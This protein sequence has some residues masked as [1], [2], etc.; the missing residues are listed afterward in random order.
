MIPATAKNTAGGI[1][2]PFPSLYSLPPFRC[3]GNANKELCAHTEQ[4]H[5]EQLEAI[6]NAL[7]GQE[8][9]DLEI[10]VTEGIPESEVNAHNQKILAAVAQ[11]EA[12]RRAASG[13]SGK[14]TRLEGRP[15]TGVS[16]QVY[17]FRTN[18]PRG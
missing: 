8:S 12:D 5:K 6:D 1:Y 4:A 14:C 9:I 16:R 11:R 18:P 17:K 15:D 13:Q 2:S 7:P 10:F 3:P